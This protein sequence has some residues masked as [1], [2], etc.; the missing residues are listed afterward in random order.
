MA[1]SISLSS[2]MTTL[3]FLDSSGSSFGQAFSLT[4]NGVNITS[5]SG[6]VNVVAA[7]SPLQNGTDDFSTADVAQWD[8]TFHENTNQLMMIGN[9]DIESQF[10]GNVNKYPL[11]GGETYNLRLNSAQTKL[12]I[13]TRGK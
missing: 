10:N 3:Y 9:D 7:T 12:L 4:G 8:A 2:D 13:R 5:T 1:N 6:D 11:A